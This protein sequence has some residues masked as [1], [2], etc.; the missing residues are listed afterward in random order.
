VA[1]PTTL[2]PPPELDQRLLEP[3]RHHWRGWLI[4]LAVV[5]GIAVFGG[6]V[7]DWLGMLPWRGPLSTGAAQLNGVSTTFDVVAGQRIAYPLLSVSDSSRIGVVLDSVEPVD[8][9]PGVYVKDAWLFVD[10]PRCHRLAPNFPA[11][12]PQECRRPMAGSSLPGH[13][14]GN[15]GTRVIVVLEASGPGTYR[16]S[17]FD[18][19][20]HVGPIHY[21]TTF[22]DGYMIRATASHPSRKHKPSS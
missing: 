7:L 9:T 10:S 2:T 14:Y 8:A 1:S 19:H 3:R 6:L 11:G 17:G 20:Y 13:Q 22:G 18:V 15:T 21:T 5:V 16:A 12:V 4:A